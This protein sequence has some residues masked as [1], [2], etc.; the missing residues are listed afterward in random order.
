MFTTFMPVPPPSSDDNAW[1][2]DSEHPDGI[3]ATEDHLLRPPNAP[4]NPFDSDSNT[5]LSSPSSSC[6][7]LYNDAVAQTTPHAISRKPPPP[8]PPR[9]TK[10]P[11]TGNMVDIT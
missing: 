5:T 7:E 9:S 4:P 3:Y 2:I 1:W 10:P 11:L 8:P 6:E